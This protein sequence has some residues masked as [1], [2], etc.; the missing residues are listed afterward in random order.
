MI[1]DYLLT[2]VPVI[3]S[4]TGIAIISKIAITVVKHV[5]N[6]KNEEVEQ[7]KRRNKLLE[8]ENL[9]LKNT[10]ANIDMRIENNIKNQEIIIKEVGMVVDEQRKSNEQASK[11]ID[12]GTTI[13]NELRTLLEAKKE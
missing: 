4:T 6:K 13:R 1:V 11:I 2:L 5:A 3:T 12:S 9:S 10:L 7:L 8:E